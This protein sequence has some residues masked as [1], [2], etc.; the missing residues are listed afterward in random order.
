MQRWHG[1]ELE[2]LLMTAAIIPVIFLI[3]LV[4]YGATEDLILGE[5]K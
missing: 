3:V 2:R 1:N 4:V 5:S